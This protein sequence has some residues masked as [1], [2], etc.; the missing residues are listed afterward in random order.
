VLNQAK[1]ELRIAAETLPPHA[2]PVL[3]AALVM[4]TSA[5]DSRGH[6]VLLSCC[7][8]LGRNST[9]VLYPESSRMTPSYGTFTSPLR[10]GGPSGA[11]IGGQKSSVRTRSG[12]RSEGH[13][14]ASVPH[15]R[16]LPRP[17]EGSAAARPRSLSR[18]SSPPGPSFHLDG[19]Q[20]GRRRWLM[21]VTG[22]RCFRTFT[23]EIQ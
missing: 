17:S 6:G 3:R 8:P 12:R 14:P 1:V 2:V 10:G 21:R 18:M 20:E 4:T 11:G 9:Q 15:S 16:E 5:D 23:G 7:G 19:G 22:Y 13:R